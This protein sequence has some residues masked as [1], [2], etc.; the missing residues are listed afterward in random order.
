MSI[1]LYLLNFAGFCL[2]FFPH[3]LL[4]CLLCDPSSLRLNARTVSIALAGICVSGA[5]I[6]PFFSQSD[7][8]GLF[9]AAFFF[10]WFLLLRDSVTKKIFVL[11]LA[12]AVFSGQ[13]ALLLSADLAKT[14]TESPDVEAA[15][16]ESVALNSPA[17]VALLVLADILLIPAAAVFAKRLLKPYLRMAKAG[18]MWLEMSLLFVAGLVLFLVSFFC[19]GL[20]IAVTARPWVALLSTAFFLAAW[21]ALFYTL[22]R[23]AL[24]RALEADNRLQMELIREN[25]KHLQNEMYRSRVIYHDLRQLLRQLYTLN[26]QANAAELRPYVEK[27]IE[28]TEHS[29]TV[30]CENKCLNALLQYYS[31]CARENDIPITVSAVCGEVPVDDADM[32]ILLANAL[33][34]AITGAQEYRTRTRLEPDI[35]VVI[36]I[37]QN[38][39]AVQITNSC[40]AAQYAPH[41]A[42]KAKGTF[43]PS[44]SYLSMHRDGGQGLKR[45]DYIVE[46]YGGH[47][48]FRFDEAASLW[49]ARLSLVIR[50]GRL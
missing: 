29:E 38:N 22:T 36:G 30:F 7:A 16:A 6:Y 13:I 8:W 23:N 44:A 15:L 1:S 31:G 3:V 34:N 28:L 17:N 41:V 11:F 40:A 2:R 4:L 49:T 9:Y 18:N 21:A 33:E 19:I 10:G 42:D 14:L 37:V 5:V 24:V 50:K 46:K 47:A 27:I 43:L 25:S 26:E 39:F 45:I 35:D 20:E 48:S 32:T 12:G